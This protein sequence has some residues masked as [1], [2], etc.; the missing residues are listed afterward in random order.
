V[1]RDLY[2]AAADATY[3]DADAAFVSRMYRSEPDMGGWS[4]PT[5]IRAFAPP[6]R[7]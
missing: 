3:R 4:T 2:T 1:L 5:S 7:R 6:G